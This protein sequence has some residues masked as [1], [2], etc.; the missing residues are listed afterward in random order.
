MDRRCFFFSVS[1]DFVQQITQEKLLFEMEKI[2]SRCKLDA[3]N[4]MINLEEEL[5]DVEDKKKFSRKVRIDN[6]DLRGGKLMYELA[7]VGRKVEALKTKL[8][9]EMNF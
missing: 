6:E 9:L 7:I 4:E 5:Q 2:S 1:S 8:F 3:L